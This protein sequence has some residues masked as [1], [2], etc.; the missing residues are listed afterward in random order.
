MSSQSSD[1]SSFKLGS[2]F[3]LFLA[4]FH[5]GRG[6]R[7]KKWGRRRRKEKGER[8]EE[9]RAKRESVREPKIFFFF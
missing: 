9:Q 8:G 2:F 6:R 5:I 1:L 4:S 7:N 3:F